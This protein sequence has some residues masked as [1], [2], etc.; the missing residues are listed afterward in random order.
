MKSRTQ[1]NRKILRTHVMIGL[2]FLCSIMG[3]SQSVSTNGIVVKEVTKVENMSIAIT[4]D[5]ADD[6]DSTFQ[7]KDIKEILGDLSEDETISF[8]IICNGKKMSNGIKSHVSYKVDGNSNDLNTFI[9]TVEK[10]RTAALK[11]YN[12]KE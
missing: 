9:A 4:V 6:L 3:F 7:V 5:S 2:V 8:K 10:I 12:N 1:N 11:Y